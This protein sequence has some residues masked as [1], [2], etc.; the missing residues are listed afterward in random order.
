MGPVSRL[1]DLIIGSQTLAPDSRGAYVISGQTL[2]PGGLVTFAGTPIS[3][4]PSASGVVVG[5]TTS[6]LVPPAQSIPVVTVGSSAYTANSASDFVINGQT[7]APGSVITV[8]GTA[9]SLLPSASGIVVGSSTSL[10]PTPAPMA[11]AVTLGSQV[12]T[13]DTA[14]R[15]VISGQTLAPGSVIT[16]SGTLISMNSKGTAAAV[17]ASTQPVGVGALIM[18]GFGSVGGATPTATVGAPD[19]PTIPSTLS[20]ATV[21]GLTFSVDASEMVLSSTTYPIGSGAAPTTVVVGNETLILGSS[22]IVLPS[23]TI[24]A[25]GTTNVSA[26]AFTGSARSRYKIS[27]VIVEM[28]WGA[29]MAIVMSAIFA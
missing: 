14:S 16:I 9:I 1:P 17:Q 20:P 15:I 5:S 22:G 29:G 26:Q 6:W 28:V 8:S 18:S 19:K 25:D 10:F 24:V 11:P 23:T 2:T 13:A 27:G 12:Y 4:M 21:D 3:L 7:L